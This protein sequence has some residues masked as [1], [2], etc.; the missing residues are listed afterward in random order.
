MSLATEPIESTETTSAEALAEFILSFVQAFLRTGYYL[1][2][3]PRARQAKEGLY[4]RFQRL[5]AG[6]HELTFFVEDKGETKS[7]LV[8]GP[9]P[10]TQRLSALMPRGMAEVYTPRL[11]RF[12]E[13][14]DLVSLTLKEAMSEPEFCR[15]V[16]LMSEPTVAADASGHDQFLDRLRSNGVTQFSC[17]FHED[18]VSADRR[19][20]WRAQ[21]AVSRLRKDLRLVPLFHELDPERLRELHREV[22]RDV[23]RPL[24]RADLQAALLLNAD[25]ARTA[26][27]SEEQIEDDLVE[28]LPEQTLV[29]VAREALKGRLAGTDPAAAA[30]QD[31]ALLKL[32]LH[33]RFGGLPGAHE[34]VREM[35]DQGLL[36]FERL[37][38]ALRNQVL[39]ERETDRYLAERTPA[40]RAL[41]ESPTEEY[42]RGW[43]DYLL[44]VMPELLRRNR[45]D[46]VL[47]LATT[48][49]GHASLGGV[50]A[51]PAALALARMASGGLGAM[52]KDRFIHG[53]KQDRVALAPT[54]L[55][56]GEPAR[57]MLRDVLREAKDPWVRKN[58]CE[59]LLR[60][61]PAGEELVLAELGSPAL[62]PSTAAE[63]LMVLA[64]VGAASPSA[65]E[66]LRHHL[67]HP[68][69][70]VRGEA[71]WSLC[72]LRGAAE[73]ESFIALLD[74]P[75]LDVR[76]RAVRCLR[77]VK[78]RRA[79]PRLLEVLDR[80]RE[81]PGLEPLAVVVY[82][83][84]GAFP[85]GDVAPGRTA[86]DVLLGV[87]GEA[88]PRGLRAVLARRRPTLSE[89][90]FWAVC[91]SLGAVGGPDSAEALDAL[92][93]HVE[94]PARSR[95]R[96]LLHQIEARAGSLAY[97]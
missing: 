66:A 25:L 14:K 1:P 53:H 75:D 24:T 51:R 49:R 21:L 22:L 30:R 71:A 19:L 10:E 79:L 8:D 94:E 7:V 78:S 33:P 50:R 61:G 91:E 85:D 69:P 26:E 68:D 77:A 59:T 97:A 31:R 90:A 5:F 60:Q 46:E 18:M 54:L 67:P 42:Y 89:D 64:E 27:V 87:L 47:A 29:A 43:T 20:P 96:G 83:A 92:A 86:E 80:A 17:V 84:L 58:A 9:L 39:L 41:E 15:F 74:D 52:L 4:S 16:D 81:D 57:G 73:E 40:L 48:F 55:A 88:Y 72:R 56:L 93:R 11:A 95:L 70:R 44:A 62:G 45:L 34:V 3:H 37:P 12:L 63:V 28:C 6:R 36:D 23:L 2:E 65:V 38:E 13:R 76:R 82:H 32:A 35:H